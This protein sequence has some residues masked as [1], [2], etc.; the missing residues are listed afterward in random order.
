MMLNSELRSA[1]ADQEG[2]PGVVIYYPIQQAYAAA[3]KLNVGR[4]WQKYLESDRGCHF[5]TI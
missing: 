2:D 4:H 1:T 5:N 3:A